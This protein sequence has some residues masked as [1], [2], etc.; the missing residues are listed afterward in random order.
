[1]MVLLT[2]IAAPA[3]AAADV[4]DNGNN[5]IVGSLPYSNQ[6]FYDQRQSI[7]YVSF[8]HARMGDGMIR[9]GEFTGD[10]GGSDL[11][12]P[13]ID[14][15]VTVLQFSGRDG[16]NGF[17]RRLSLGMRYGLGVGLKKGALTNSDFSINAAS[18]SVYLSAGM[19]RLGP[20]LAYD[21]ASWLQPYVGVEI[22][23]FVFRQSSSMSVAE[24]QGA[25]ALFGTV[26]GLHLPA[27]FSQRASIYA[28]VRNS[29][30]LSDEKQVF[31]SSTS[32]TGGVGMVF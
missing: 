9:S 15:F 4:S 1:M 14:Y 29:K 31:G 3:L 22:A 30:V 8:N 10:Y 5:K 7:L 27:F 24:T 6:W 23:P 28:E 13:S 17:W 32:V 18:E 26:A 11:N 20:V 2:V 19:A 12:F 21:L 25:G 16:S